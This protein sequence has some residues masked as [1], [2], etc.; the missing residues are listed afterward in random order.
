MRPSLNLHAE[1]PRD[2]GNLNWSGY[3]ES[4]PDRKLG[5][6]SSDLRYPQLR[7]FPRCQPKTAPASTPLCIDLAVP[8]SRHPESIVRSECTG[9][10]RWSVRRTIRL[11]TSRP[12][13]GLS[14]LQVKLQILFVDA[15]TH[16]DTR[17][18]VF[19]GLRMARKVRLTNLPRDRLPRCSC[20]L[21]QIGFG[22]QLH[23]HLP[24]SR[25]RGNKKPGAV[26][27]FRLS[28]LHT[29]E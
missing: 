8:V 9:C 19:A 10:R 29:Q 3:R 23:A 7:V 16:G 26:A 1:V 21:Q 24:E 5:R 28:V 11:S 14:W 15:P 17:V 20:A 22:L 2:W 13:R 27:G 18:E 25:I 6:L 4:N 12:S